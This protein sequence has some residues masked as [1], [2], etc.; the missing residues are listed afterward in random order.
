[1]DRLAGLV[2]GPSE[3][4]LRALG[5]GRGVGPWTLSCLAAQT[6]GEADAAVVGD[7]GI[8]ALVAWLLAGERTADDARML[9][10]LEPYRPHRGRVIRLAFLSGARPPRRQPGLPG[11]DIRR[12]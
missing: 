4:G 5:A 8:P 12:L 3:A 6:S 2:D 7:A 11:V 9:A 10:L 1:V